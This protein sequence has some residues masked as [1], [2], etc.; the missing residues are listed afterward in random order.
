M[1]DSVAMAVEDG[2]GGMWGGAPGRRPT[3][4]MRMMVV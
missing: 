4:I 3:V 2:C 1:D